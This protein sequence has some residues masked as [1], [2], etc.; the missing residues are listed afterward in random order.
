MTEERRNLRVI[1]D[2]VKND[3]GKERIST[4]K[5]DTRAVARH[6][7]N[8]PSRVFDYKELA[9]IGHGA[10]WPNLAE[11]ARHKIRAI[12]N[13]LEEQGVATVVEFSGRR[14]AAIQVY[15]SSNEYHQQLMADEMARRRLRADGSAE[16]LE[17]LLALMPPPE[18]QP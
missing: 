10:A 15:A 9:R 17:V 1:P 6:V 14:L 2:I 5:W 3:M 13:L 4:G 16:K 11:D 18:P 7:A 12:A 8:N